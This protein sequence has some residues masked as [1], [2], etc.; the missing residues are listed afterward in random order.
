M[1]KVVHILMLGMSS[2][3]INFLIITAIVASNFAVTFDQ[4]FYVS[5]T[6]FVLGPIIF[7]IVSGI[8]FARPIITGP[9]TSIAIIVS[10]QFVNTTCKMKKKFK[11]F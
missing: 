11:Y 5:T 4:T 8:T 7:T 2:E 10:W 1:K 9:T 6:I 3:N